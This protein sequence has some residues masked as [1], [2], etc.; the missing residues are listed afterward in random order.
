MTGSA[1]GARAWTRFPWGLASAALAYVLARALVIHTAF[2]EVSPWVYELSPMGTLAELLRR[3]VPIPPHFFYDN[4]GGQLLA[5]YLTVPAFWIL[6]P[7]YLAL[8]I[9][10]FGMGLATLFLVHAFLRD[11]FGRRAAVLGAWFVALAPTT[12]FKYSVVCSGNHPENVFFSMVVLTLF[13]RLERGEITA[14]GLFVLGAASGLALFNSLGSLVLLGILA[15]VHAG[16]RGLRASARDLP[17]VASGF[18]LG[19]LPLLLVNAMTR[20]RGVSY[21]AAKFGE[22]TAGLASGPVRV[23]S[24]AGRFLF[25][26][27]PEA[28]CYPDLRWIRGSTLGV[29]FALACAAACAAALPG[30][31][32]GTRALL[33]GALQSS[34]LA[35]RRVRLKSAGLVPVLL[36]LPVSALAFGLSNLVVRE[37]TADSFGFIAFRYYLP[38]FLC[39]LIAVAAISDRAWRRGGAFRVAAVL[40]AAAVLV[41]GASNL[42]LIDWSFSRTGLGRAYDGYDLTRIGRSLVSPRVGLQREEI[43]GYLGRLEPAMRARV[44]RG[45]GF[46][47]AVVQITSAR[48]AGASPGT[49]STIDFDSIAGGY[50]AEDGPELARGA[51]AA[52]RFEGTVGGSTPV[53]LLEKIAAN[54]PAFGD[55]STAYL[56]GVCLPTLNAPPAQGTAAGLALDANLLARSVESQLPARILDGL[57]RGEGCLCGMLLRRGIASDRRSVESTAQGV[58]ADLRESFFRGLGAG[59]A[60]GAE[61]SALPIGFE[62]PPAERPPFWTGFAARLL[63]VDADGA[64][65]RAGEIAADLADPDRELL[66]RALS[67]P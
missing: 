24:R 12:F 47:L 6:G 23:L 43:L 33:S 2:D 31:V 58:P 61:R 65:R 52:L 67:R 44:L 51:G 36:H 41:P 45:I 10:P 13:F 1:T 17:A 16:L 34:D 55:R 21:L 7:S 38:C 29:L 9:L 8:K 46:N 62:I 49:G 25:A 15:G 53:A 57:A 18:L 37:S 64:R 35:G 26:R 63:E 66:E 28:A 30:A 56:E 60:D 42:A 39:A 59:W 3:G 4:A 54:E 50:P 5:A 27:W 40:L 48:R 11:A 20:G 14:R 19:A 32:R 22:P